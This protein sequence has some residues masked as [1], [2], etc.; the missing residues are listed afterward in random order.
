MRLEKVKTLFRLGLRNGMGL[1]IPVLT[2]RIN[3]V[4]KQWS[5]LALQIGRVVSFF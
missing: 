5:A 3:R 4:L 1:P 2:V